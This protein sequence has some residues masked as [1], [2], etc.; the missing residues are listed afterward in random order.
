MNHVFVVPEGEAAEAVR[1]VVFQVTVSV[2]PSV[3]LILKV[4]VPLLLLTRVEDTMPLP[5][6]PRGPVPPEPPKEEMPREFVITDILNQS[7]SM[8]VR[9]L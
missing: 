2:V 5:G 1:L 6:A 8:N 3:I 4:K 9:N 7:T